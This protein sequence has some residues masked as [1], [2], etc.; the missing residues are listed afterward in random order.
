[1]TATSDWRNMTQLKPTPGTRVAVLSAALLLCSYLPAGAYAQVLKCVDAAGNVQFSNLGCPSTNPG[2]IVEVRPNAVDMSGMRKQNQAEL[3]AQQRR[4]QREQV[5]PMLQSGV[6]ASVCPSEVEIRNM[7]VSAGSQSRSAKER[8]FFQDEVRR[9]RQCRN[10]QGVYTAADWAISREAQGDQG[11]FQT[12]RAK[13]ARV[14]AAGM[15]SAADPIEG[16]RIAQERL[17]EASRVAARRRAAQASHVITSCDPGGCWDSL[18]NRY[19]R[20]GPTFFSTTGRACRRVGNMLQC[21]P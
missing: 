2:R 18:G 19:N 21:D 12:S 5:M 8:Q 9:A 15:H 6:N 10:G 16:D 4:R 13:Q 14:R 20:S 3:A 11:Q 1:M 7:E 17:D